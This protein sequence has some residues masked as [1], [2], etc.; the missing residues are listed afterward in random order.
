M[1]ARPGPDAD[2]DRTTAQL[3]ELIREAHGAVKDLRAAIRD[4]KALAAVAADAAAL[5][6]HDAAAEEMQRGADH[7]QREMNQQA[8]Q[9]NRAVQAARRHI[10]AQLATAW[11]EPPDESGRFQIKF[12][13]PL[14]DDQIEAGEG[15]EAE[16][17]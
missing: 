12:E 5:A 14:F 15:T 16:S 3:R 4:A 6:A 2:A 8:T 11:L 7:L 17:R 9:L 1:T 13:V 10:V